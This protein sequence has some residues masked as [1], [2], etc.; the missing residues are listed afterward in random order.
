MTVDQTVLEAK[1]YGIFSCKPEQTLL[2][3]ACQMAEKDVSALVVLDHQN[4]LQGVLS[5]TDLIRA[6]VFEP[7]KVKLLNKI[8]FLL[9]RLSLNDDAARFADRA[10]A[11]DSAYI[12]ALVNRGI[13]HARSGELDAAERLFNRALQLEGTNLDALYNSMLLSRKKGDYRRADD[14]ERKLQALTPAGR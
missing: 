8:A 10:I 14:I 11:L 2:Q 13:I 1:R 4:R 5:R 6:L 3:A 9:M 7:D 12:P